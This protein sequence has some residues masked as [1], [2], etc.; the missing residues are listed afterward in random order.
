[1]ASY[2]MDSSLSDINAHPDILAQHQHQQPQWATL[3]LAGSGSQPAPN[4]PPQSAGQSDHVDDWAGTWQGLPGIDALIAG[5]EEAMGTGPAANDTNSV[6]RTVPPAPGWEGASYQ[7]VMDQPPPPMSAWHSPASSN[8]S[9]PGQPPILSSFQQFSHHPLHSPFHNNHIAPQASP[10]AIPFDHPNIPPPF[11]PRYTTSYSLPNSPLPSHSRLPPF[12]RLSMSTRSSPGLHPLVPGSP[13]PFSQFHLN[14]MDTN[15]P[16]SPFL[17]SDNGSDQSIMSVGSYHPSPNKSVDGG[18]TNATGGGDDEVVDLTEADADDDVVLVEEAPSTPKKRKQSPAT[19]ARECKR[20]NNAP[21]AFMPHTAAH[22]A[23]AYMDHPTTLSTPPPG[24]C[25]GPTNWAGQAGPSGSD[26]LAPRP[27]F[28][29]SHHHPHH[30]AIL[31]SHSHSHHPQPLSP[32]ARYAGGGKG[33]AGFG[34]TQLK[35][36]GSASSIA[37]N[38]SSVGGFGGGFGRSSVGGPLKR[39]KEV[40]PPDPDVV[41]V[42]DGKCDDCGDRCNISELDS[43]GPDVT[44]IADDTPANT[45]D[46]IDLTDVS[47]EE[48][49]RLKALAMQRE[50]EARERRKA[51]KAANS[52]IVAYGQVMTPLIDFEKA[53]FSEAMAKGRSGGGGKELHVDIKP[54]TGMGGKSLTGLL[55]YSNNIQIGRLDPRSYQAFGRLLFQKKRAHIEGRLGTSKFNQHTALV[56]WTVLGPLQNANDVGMVLSQF[57]LKLEPLTRHIQY[58]YVNPH[59]AGG[60]VGWGGPGCNRF[61][62]VSAAGTV[63]GGSGE[64][65]VKSQIENIYKSLGSVGD[66]PEAEAAD[67]LASPLYP[68]QKQALWWMLEREKV[69]DYDD[70]A[71]SSTAGGKVTI[72]Q[73]ENARSYR[74]MI[75]SESRETPPRQCRGGILADDMGLG[76]TLELISLLLTT[77]PPTPV[78]RPPPSPPPPSSK[79]SKPRHPFLPGGMATPPSVLPP[80]PGGSVPSRATLVVCPLSTVG[81]WEEQVGTHVEE[82]VLRVLVY[83]GGGRERIV[84]E[85]AKYDVVITTY[86]LLALEFGRDEKLRKQTQDPAIC[87]SV[88]QQIYWFRVVL[89]EAHIIKEPSTAQAKAACALRAERR[90]ALT[91]T[92]IQNRLEDLYSLIK[93]LSLQPFDSKQHFNHFIMRPIKAGN[94]IGVTRLQTLTKSV[95]LRR[96]KQTFIN[97]KPILSLPERKDLKIQ[98][99]LTETERD[100]YEAVKE[101]SVGVFKRLEAEGTLLKNYVHLLELILRLRQAATHPALCRDYEKDFK[102]IEAGKGT[103]SSEPFTLIQAMHMYALMKDAGDEACGICGINV[104]GGQTVEGEERETFPVVGRCGHLLC[105][106]CAGAVLKGK[107]GDGESGPTVGCGLC[108]RILGKEDLVA[109]KDNDSAAEPDDDVSM[110][111]DPSG[112]GAPSS[113]SGSKLPLAHIQ[114]STKVSW[115]IQNL[116]EV[117]NECFQRGEAQT[118]SII[119]SQ[120]T[121]MLDLLEVPLTQYSFKFCR[122]DGK[123]TRPDRNAAMHKLK[124]DPEVTV[125]LV[126]LKA[127][128]VGL[129]LTSASRCYIMEPYWN[130]AV[131]QQAIDR[132]HR[133][134]QTRVVHTIR[135]VVKD[136]IEESILK[137]QQDKL[138]MAQKAFREGEMSN[139]EWTDQVKR[140]KKGK[141]AIGEAARKKAEA[142]QTRIR[143]LKALL[144]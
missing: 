121:G 26:L 141:S 80:I 58:R 33:F 125:M 37:S 114:P 134:G 132:I 66:L 124:E 2:D 86:N 75:T 113:L 144:G 137:M 78:V 72:W 27:S 92:P 22:H 4:E 107:K 71:Y 18:G 7:S 14:G 89:D 74:N 10:P 5:S 85:V 133:L 84:E 128:G 8:A 34:G 11:D 140:G 97:G 35:R 112:D 52:E 56:T 82:G 103:S 67:R 30:Q 117:R 79:N 101:R 76:K 102:A 142:Q 31:P 28:L 77:I 83:H 105:S 12:E 123:M 120:W 48:E 24:L 41:V 64:D 122:L 98:L 136:T 38:G 118:K 23:G 21:F 106:Q 95:T 51:E 16:E 99:E 9:I 13:L 109:V 60:S 110:K 65:A 17:I 62:G 39:E 91:G 130:P 19:Y 104:E 73:K 32:F 90:W 15:R 131:E 143:D 40:R 20:H 88:L 135:L 119:F 47:P 111:L 100:I 138:E 50:E 129:N 57:G 55:A 70:P 116:L 45:S 49:A 3:A 108:G 127:G 96:T 59:S 68:H 43:E 44:K 46:S 69:V 1:M 53:A 25:S 87:K 94:V 139:E 115:L 6:A 29:H 126:S 93:F 42:S 36:V 81:N 63:M 54:E 61:A